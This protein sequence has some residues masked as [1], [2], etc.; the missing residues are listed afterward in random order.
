MFLTWGDIL[1]S[2]AFCAK[3]HFPI[4]PKSAPS[5]LSNFAPEGS[6]ESHRGSKMTAMAM[7]VG[8]EGIFKAPS[9]T[10]NE[11]FVKYYFLANAP[12]RK[13]HFSIHIVCLYDFRPEM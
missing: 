8:T 4:A 3:V 5:V 9:L 11:I 7:L 13:W 6:K 10:N 12:G 2:G 1:V